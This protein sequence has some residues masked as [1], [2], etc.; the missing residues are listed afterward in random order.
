M[1]PVLM[2]RQRKSEEARNPILGLGR[3]TLVPD[4]G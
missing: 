3:E 4:Y 1:K 2:P